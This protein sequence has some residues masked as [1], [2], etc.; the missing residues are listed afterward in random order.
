MP[1]IGCGQAGGSWFTV[2]ELIDLHLVRRGV[3]V[4]VYDLPNQVK[5]KFDQA[6]LFVGK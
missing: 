6:S 3:A 2:S 4:T 5:G 1:R